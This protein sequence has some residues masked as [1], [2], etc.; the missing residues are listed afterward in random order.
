MKMIVLRNPT[1]GNLGGFIELSSVHKS[2][3]RK[4]ARHFRWPCAI[5]A[6]TEVFKIRITILKLMQ[7]VALCEIAK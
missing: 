5:F 1:Q 7:Y 6:D 2:L 3:I 4:T